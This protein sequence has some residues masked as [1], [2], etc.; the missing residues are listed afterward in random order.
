M[1]N[2]TRFKTLGGVGAAMVFASGATMAETIPPSTT[3]SAT[4]DATIL[5]WKDGKR[6]V[7]LLEFDDSCGTHVQNAI[8]E[9]QRRGMVGT[10]YVN[11]GNGPFQSQRDAWEKEIP[12]TGMEYG[13]HTFRHK[14]APSLEVVEEDIALCNAAILSYFP[15]RKQPRL[16]S[17]GRPGGVPWTITPE[18]QAE[19]L[20]KYHLVDRPPFSGYPF[21]AKTKEDVLKL[22]DNAIAK[23]DMGHHDFHGVG[24]DWHST[25]MDIFLAL[26]DKL[27]A[28]RDVVWITDPVSYHKYLTERD[29]ADLKVV[30]GDAGRVSLQLTCGTDPALYDLPLTLR[31]QVPAAWRACSVT[32][33][34]AQVKV[35]V[36]HGTIQ[37]DATPVTGEI[38]IRPVAR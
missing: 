23:G 13:N 5:K 14:G 9:L 34:S 37:F 33:G 16:I 10:F 12:L 24:G 36:A 22:V 21:H 6:A 2:L 11:P 8:P 17:F 3:A 38:V 29:G 28:C 20:K 25:P 35:D 19:L 18:Q 7:F 15:D 31:T 27:E 1:T 32:Q 26:L 30:A 4:D